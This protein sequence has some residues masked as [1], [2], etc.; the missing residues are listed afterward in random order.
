[1]QDIERRLQTDLPPW[2][3]KRV[4]VYP[5]TLNSSG[6]R[7][8]AREGWGYTLRADTKEGMRQLIRKQLD[9]SK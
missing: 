8:Y 7:W 5:A 1:M 9:R 6:I 4:N 3:Y 2:K